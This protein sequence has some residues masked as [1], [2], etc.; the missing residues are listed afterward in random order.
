M[1]FAR[2]FSATLVVA[3]VLLGGC[4]SMKESRTINK[5]GT[6]T[7]TRS[8]EGWLPA[9][10]IGI[11]LGAGVYD[12]GSGNAVIYDRGSAN[13]AAE[14]RVYDTSR[15]PELVTRRDR[16]GHVIQMYWICSGGREPVAGKC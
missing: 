16:N 8:F 15:S 12:Y 3:A 9:A 6:T 10:G 1:L 7:V 14:I 11:G 13:R 5:D 4:G 2:F